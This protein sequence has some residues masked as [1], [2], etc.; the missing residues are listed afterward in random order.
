[1]KAKPASVSRED[2]LRKLQS[3]YTIEAA[4]QHLFGL[5]ADRYLVA[6]EDRGSYR[7]RASE[8]REELS[9]LT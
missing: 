7:R 3:I 2:W 1:M 4:T 5:E 9:R 6:D 8:L